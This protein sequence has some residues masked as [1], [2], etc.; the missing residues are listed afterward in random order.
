MTV[1]LRSDIVARPTAAMIEAMVAAAGAP[2]GF[3]LREDPTVARLE[4]LAAETVGKE[5]AL[6]CPTCMMANQIAIHLHCRS[7]ENFVTEASSHVLTSEAA[8]AAS[9][10]GAMPRLVEGALGAASVEA[11]IQAGDA[12]RSRTAMVLLENTHVSSGG[13]VLPYQEMQAIAEVARRHGLAVHLDGARLFNAA[14]ALGRSGAELAATATTVAFNLNKALGAPLGALLAG[15]AEH[16]AEATRIRQMFG[17]GWRPA[18]IPA[19][20]GIVALEQGI[21]RLAD[22]HDNARRLAEG[23]TVLPGLALDPAD[24]ESNIVM[25][26]IA[27]DGLDASTLAS[28][29]AAHDVLVM[30]YG[31]RRLRCCTHHDIT[32]DGIARALAAFAAALEE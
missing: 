18:G 4:R 5:D 12:L 29:I 6:F 16:I 3:D 24:V 9:L 20:A 21:P 2:P 19:A 23:L 14:T 27:R 10:T 30:P 32:A 1:D 15:S 26:D 11:A 25:V 31:P 28:R 8:A 17:G 7:G 13:R 22:D